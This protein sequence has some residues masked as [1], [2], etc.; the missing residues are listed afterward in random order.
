MLN[1]IYEIAFSETLYYLKGISLNDINK[2][3]NRFMLFLK[4]NASKN[5]K[6]NFDYTKPLNELKLKRETRGIIA[7]ICLEFWCETEEQK[8]IFTEH[9]NKNEKEYQEELRRKYNIENIFNRNET[10]SKVEKITKDIGSNNL[11]IQVNKNSIF[12]R[13]YSSI[14]KFFHIK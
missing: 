7:M 9:L 6:C 12:K 8:R 14:I 5:Y 10:I 11:P 3:P 2:I 4:E 1:E 13:I